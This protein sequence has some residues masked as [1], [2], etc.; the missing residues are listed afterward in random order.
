VFT[1]RSVIRSLAAA[2]IL[3]ALT[4]APAA[5]AATTELNA[6]DKA[7][8]QAVH[9]A[10]LAEIAAGKLAQSKG[11][12]R[13]V[14]DLGAMMVTDH[15]KLDAALRKVAT[16]AKVSLPAAPS[17]DQRAMQA[18][19]ASAPT[20]EFDAM[21]VSAQIVGHAEV[22]RLGAREEAA[23]R[24]AAVKKAA[25]EAAPIV[26]GHYDKFVAEAKMMGLPGFVKAGRTS[27]LATSG[28]SGNE[29]TVPLL[30][31]GLILIGGGGVLVRRRVVA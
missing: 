7:Y 9:Q 18:K 16:A 10:N 8:L 29:W 27:D 12:S 15:T 5:H 17:A 24:D 4:T 11:S 26:V 3:L 19:L 21:Y 25:A 1:Y 14:K 2:V 28:S 22:M 6:Q 30:M 31:A 23:G 13:Q 20:G